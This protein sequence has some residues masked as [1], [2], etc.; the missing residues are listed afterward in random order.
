MK[1]NETTHIIAGLVIFGLLIVG[2]FWIANSDDSLTRD[3]ATN[4][5]YLLENKTERMECLGYAEQVFESNLR[6][7]TGESWTPGQ[8]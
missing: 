5:C 6:E 7:P 1:D 3:E 8:W 4:H 2:G